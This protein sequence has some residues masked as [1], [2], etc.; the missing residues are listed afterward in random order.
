MFKIMNRD[1]DDP[2]YHDPSVP[3]R[4]LVY[5]PSMSDM[6][7]KKLTE[8]QEDIIRELTDEYPSMDNFDESKDQVD[9]AIERFEKEVNEVEG[10][11]DDENNENDEYYEAYELENEG[12]DEYEFMGFNNKV[13]KEFAKEVH[14]NLVYAPAEGVKM[15]EYDAFGLP[16]T[17]EMEMIKR[18]LN[19]NDQDAIEAE[20]VDVMYI[21]PP[22]E[23][24]LHGYHRNV[25]IERKNMNKEMKEVFDMMEDDKHINEN[26]ELIDDDF[27]NQLNDG[28]PAV[29][30]K[31]GEVV[32]DLNA[33]DDLME[34]AKRQADMML[35]NM[36]PELS[37]DMQIKLAAAREHLALKNKEVEKNPEIQAHIDNDFEQMLDEY[38][39]D[40][41]GMANPELFEDMEDEIDQDEFDDI[42]QEFI[43][44]NATRCKKMLE[45]YQDSE[46]ESKVKIGLENDPLNTT[47]D[48]KEAVFKLLKQKNGEIVRLVSKEF[49]DRFKKEMSDKEYEEN[50]DQIKQKV[51][52]FA[53]EFLAKVEEGGENEHPPDREVAGEGDEETWDVETVLTTKTNTDNHPGIIR[54]IVRPKQNPIKLDPKTRAPELESVTKV[55]EKP[56]KKQGPY[57]E[58]EQSDEEVEE[59][60]L[61]DMTPEEIAR[62]DK[63]QYKKMVKKERRERRAM[64]KQLKK[65]FSRQ[66]QKYAQS[67]TVNKGQIRPGTS[68]KK[69]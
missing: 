42:L 7:R 48:A 29:V 25:D 34:E 2:L 28:M 53:D 66:S 64:K 19:L 35:I 32:N 14:E 4:M 45:K 39:E 38:Q 51:L 6:K 23:Y 57:V 1:P 20:N 13:D 36:P 65:E 67:R 60:H 52:K 17:K 41:I 22:E 62:M 16:K 63:K 26:E 68:I 61:K 40:D 44:Q 33:E 50:K 43:N 37:L 5:T 31:D 24:V 69:L 58:I 21:K 15:I 9:Y 3:N 56:D 10:E 18:E 59:D 46:F 27:L 30:K 11:S 54:T 47:T 49:M 12:D 8:K 55:E